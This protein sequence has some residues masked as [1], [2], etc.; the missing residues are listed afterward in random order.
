M[1]SSSPSRNRTKWRCSS[2]WSRPRCLA[3]V[4]NR[5]SPVSLLPA[6]P[7]RPTLRALSGAI[8]PPSLAH[9]V[10]RSNVVVEAAQVCRIVGCLDLRQTCVVRSVG[11]SLDTLN[12]LLGEFADLWAV[13]DVRRPLILDVQRHQLRRTEG[14]STRGSR[15]AWP[16]PI[17]ASCYQRYR[18]LTPT[19]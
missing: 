16:N 3:T 12:H 2:T 17:Y 5:R 15:I 6:R 8:A 13:S 14:P 19:G 18:F 9:S 4:R 10:G 7:R 1:S 11:H